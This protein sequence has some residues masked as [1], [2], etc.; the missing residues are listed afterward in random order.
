[1]Q[2]A[3]TIEQANVFEIKEKKLERNIETSNGCFQLYKTMIKQIKTILSA[4]IFDHAL[5]DM[6]KPQYYIQL[7]IQTIFI[8]Q[9][10]SRQ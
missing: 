3:N 4:F 10:L 2:Q 5:F 8:G 9:S 1:M 7:A 6:S